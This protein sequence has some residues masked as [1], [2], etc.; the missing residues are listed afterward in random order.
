MQFHLL[1]DD[2][3]PEGCS[4][5]SPKVSRICCDLCHPHS[6]TNVAPIV[7]PT[8]S[9]GPNR[10]NV[11]QYDAAEHDRELFSELQKWRDEKA[12]VAL[13]YATFEEWGAEMFMSDETL[14]RLVDCAHV[15]KLQTVEA[16][17]RETHWRKDHIAKFSPSLLEIIT[18]CAPA[19]SVPPVKSTTR[20]C[21]ACGNPGHNSK[22]MVIQIEYCY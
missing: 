20:N 21:S 6:F 15:G 13:G 3:S 11:K 19:P 2:T 7:I 14:Q 10:T 12:M 9:R 4:R 8:S 17:H 22:Q 1:C 18:L 16:I 5:C